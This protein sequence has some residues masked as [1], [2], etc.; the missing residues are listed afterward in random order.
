M[1][2]RE[3]MLERTE[4]FNVYTHYLEVFVP[5][6]KDGIRFRSK[7]YMREAILFYRTAM[8]LFV[9]YHCDFKLRLY[10]A[11]CYMRQTTY[12]H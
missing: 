1:C 9:E 2:D 5:D 3:S 4:F 6:N 12:R 10:L 11:E 8:F 7:T